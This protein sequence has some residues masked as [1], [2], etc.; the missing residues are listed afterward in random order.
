MFVSRFVKLALA[1]ATL[2]GQPISAK[3]HCTPSVR[4]EWR[5]LTPGERVEWIDAVKVEHVP[6]GVTLT[7]LTLPRAVSQQAA[8]QLF[9][10]AD[11]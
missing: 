6:F 5:S 7:E 10:G 2:F 4:R 1:A 3:P 8:S 11:L 9:F